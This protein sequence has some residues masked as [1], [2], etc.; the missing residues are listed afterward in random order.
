MSRLRHG[1]PMTPSAI[2]KYG[3]IDRVLRA[4]QTQSIVEVGPGVAAMSWRI[5]A[6]RE[7]HGYEPDRTSFL[8][9]SE[10]LQRMGRAHL[11]NRELPKEPEMTVDAAVAFEV[12]EHM[13]D[14]QRTLEH[15][16]EWIRPGGILLIS[17][18]A[19][20]HRFG[21][22]DAKV[23]HFR[24]YGREELASRMRGAGLVDIEIRAYGM[25]IG[26]VLEWLRQKVLSR[27]LGDADCSEGT[28]RSGRSYQPKQWSG[29]LGAVMAPFVIMQ[30]PFANTDVGTGWIAWGTRPS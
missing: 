1:P 23:G 15:W 29:L 2:L 24:R 25:P 16:T 11:H 9:A 5:A 13:E 10:R 27:Q 12:L 26:F 8:I 21:P 3:T 14:D 30:K 6:G 20:Q 7:Y 22:W 18:P 17:V 4:H 28:A 19:H